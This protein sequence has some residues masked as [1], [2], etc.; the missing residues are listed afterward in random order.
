MLTII[1]MVWYE[2]STG[3]NAGN[4]PLGW[5]F[6]YGPIS[7]ALGQLIAMVQWWFKN[8]NEGKYNGVSP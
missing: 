7:A 6:F 1:A 8:G 2:A 3:Y 5:I 4:G